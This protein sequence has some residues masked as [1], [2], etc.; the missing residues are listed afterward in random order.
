MILIL[1]I[2]A[3]LALLLIVAYFT[4]KG[5]NQKHTNVDFFIGGRRSPWWTVSLGMIGASISGVTF[6]SVPGW[7]TSIHF[8]YLQMA[9]GFIVGYVIV[10]MVLLPVYY[11]ANTVSIY[12][13]LE[14]KLGRIGRRTAAV[15]FLLNK[16]LSSSVKLYVVVLVVH[17]L[18]F[19]QYGIPFW[20]VA[21]GSLLMVWLYTWKGGIRTIVW[22]DFLQTI[23]LVV[24][25]ILLIHAALKTLNISFLDAAK[26]VYDSPLSET[27]VWDDW[28]SKQHFVKQFLSGIFIVLVMTGLDQ[29]L[30]QKNLSCKNL[31]ESQRNMLSYGVLFVPLNLL[32]LALGVLIV[33]I[34]TKNGNPL[35][36][37]GDNLLPYF[38]KEM[39]TFGLVCFVIGMLASS[40]SS[41][42]S[43]IASITTS[44][45]VDFSKQEANKRKRIV[46]HILVTLVF[47]LLVVGLQQARNSHAIDLI[48]TIVSFFYG[49]VLG[50]FAFCFAQKTV[51]Q[52]LRFI[53]LSAVLSIAFA[54]LISTL[55]KQE[56]G[57]AMGYE[58]LILNGLLMYVGLW[59]ENKISLEKQNH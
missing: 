46:I 9:I 12:A 3:Y 42:D 52:N 43:A 45:S 38:A 28:M 49:P 31:K 18:V 35:P 10:A 1:S 44:I 30:M 6:V 26:L 24:A 11:A 22:T 8:T 25:L 59:I 48:Y 57:Y 32:F 5:D 33:T 40:F 4:T 13:I 54:Y 47:L 37:T 7:V 29:D 15:C 17:K 14:K 51:S 2:I 23:L 34:Y 21:L 19:A 50:L 20:A 41:V 36:A 56:F 58:L 55:L 53:P 39:G 16:A 27:F